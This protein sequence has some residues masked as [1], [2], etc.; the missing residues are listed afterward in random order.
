[1]KILLIG[2]SGLVGT[3]IEHVCA[4]KKYELI[5][6][7]HTEVD[8][9]NKN[10]LEEL[11]AMHRPAAVINSV[12]M[13]GIAPC[14]DQPAETFAINTTPAMHLAK[15]CSRAGS[16]F[17]QFSTH[18]VFD[19]LKDTPYTEDDAPNPVNIYGA[20]KLMSEYLALNMTERHY[21][22]RFSTLFGKRRNNAMG[23]VDKVLKKLE[24]N[25]PLRI[26]DDRMDTPTYA[27]DAARELFKLIES[28]KPFGLYHI[29]NAGSVSYY[30]FTARL[31]DRMKSSSDL[32][33]GKDSDFPSKTKKPLKTHIIS[34]RIG[35]MR[36]W[37]DALDAFLADRAGR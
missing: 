8:I 28:E 26:A 18:A 23:F 1:M 32:S 24:D 12:A 19:G 31:K 37:A 25:T 20:S 22:L 6:P 7:G 14:E 29:A 3:A 13:V 11:V 27:A 30:D 15:S 36:P 34:N 33:R 5:S 17:V 2:A 4:G 21:V 35:P 9:R 16:I 10:V